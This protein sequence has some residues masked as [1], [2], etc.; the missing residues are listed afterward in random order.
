MYQRNDCKLP[1]LLQVLIHRKVWDSFTSPIWFSLINSNL[2]MFCY[3]VCLFELL[4]ILAPPFPL[5]SCSSVL[6]EMFPLRLKSLPSPSNKAILNF[7]FVLFFFFK[8][9]LSTSKSK[10]FAFGFS[11]QFLSLYW[12]SIWCNSH[13]IF[14]YFFHHAFL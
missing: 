11:L 10:E 12:Y 7:W 5:L 14:L 13:H 2:L 3:M 6:S 4:Y 1:R 9:T 8:S